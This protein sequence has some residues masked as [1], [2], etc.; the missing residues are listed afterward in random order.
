MVLFL[1][2]GCLL[3]FQDDIEPV[4]EQFRV[5]YVTLDVVATHKKKMVTDLTADDFIVTENGKKVDVTFF[6]I[7]DYRQQPGEGEKPLQ[8]I[9]LA[10]D[11][12]SVI[13]S[14]V[15]G[16]FRQVRRFLDGLDENYRYSI[17]LYALDRGSLTK[18]FSEDLEE[19]GYAL[20]RYEDRFL[21]NRYRKSSWDSDN[22]LGG[23]A[24]GGSSYGMVGSGPLE[25]VN[26]ITTLIEAIRFCMGGPGECSCVNS[27]VEEFLVEQRLRSERVVGEL[28][29]LAYKF[30][31]NN[32]LK[33]MIL[34][35]PGF[36]IDNLNSV[37][38]LLRSATKGRCGSTLGI[39]R[40]RLDA[41]LQKVTH[42]CIKNRVI[43]HTFDVFNK[44][45]H[46]RQVGRDASGAIDSYA[47]DMARGLKDLAQ[48]SGGTF[49]QVFRLDGSAKKV[50]EN[51]R[52]FYTLGYQSPAG[53]PG[54]YREIKVK[55]KRKKVKVRHR[56]G[57]FG[58]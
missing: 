28:E 45:G 20:N 33:T 4:K 17:N 1:A 26:D 54:K 55:V 8:Q 52:F 50:L 38:R 49:R 13:R 37:G 22:P 47:R 57:Y 56:R 39:G 6:D 5:E 58:S 12:E 31:E 7:L 42:A 43:F 40:I 25:M 36:A 10:L 21:S 29:S 19:I 23:S 14:D 32:D 2:L 11:F 24:G 16:S 34:V 53:K 46:R 15:H 51:N 41:D 48:E 3:F 30:K 35:S 9:I 18:G 44:T 27:S